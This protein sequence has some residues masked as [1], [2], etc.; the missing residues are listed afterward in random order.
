MVFLYKR[1]STKFNYKDLAYI[2]INNYG[3]NIN[4]RVIYGNV[5]FLW[6]LR[7]FLISI[8]QNKECIN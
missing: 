6:H 4:K 1:V 5:K 7:Y 2:E 3:N 8:G